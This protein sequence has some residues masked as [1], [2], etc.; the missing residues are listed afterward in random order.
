[1]DH[2][3]PV[4]LEKGP[5]IVAD[6]LMTNK[7]ELTRALNRLMTAEEKLKSEQDISGI[8]QQSK[9]LQ[10]EER[11]RNQRRSRRNKNV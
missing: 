2:I 10:I 1:M 6:H 11:D 5:S 7:S 9:E 8:F 4:K 3:K